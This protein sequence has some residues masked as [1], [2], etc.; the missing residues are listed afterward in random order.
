MSKFRT[1][2]GLRSMITPQTIISKRNYS[3][4][5]L[6]CYDFR[7]A[8]IDKEKCSHEFERHLSKEKVLIEEIK[9]KKIRILNSG[10]KIAA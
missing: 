7:T 1:I 2:T 10:I 8:D 5:L 6:Y 4:F 3:S 9:A